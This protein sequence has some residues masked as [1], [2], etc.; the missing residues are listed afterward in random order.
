MRR[1]RGASTAEHFFYGKILQLG[2][3]GLGTRGMMAFDL[4]P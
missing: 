4:R 3:T 2:T 1:A